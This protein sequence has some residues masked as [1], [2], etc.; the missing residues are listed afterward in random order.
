M[1]Q[2][3]YKLAGQVKLPVEVLPLHPATQPPI[4]E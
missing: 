4:T 3:V 1:G 2:M